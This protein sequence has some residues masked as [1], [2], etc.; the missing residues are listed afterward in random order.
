MWSYFEP[1]KVILVIAVI[2]SL[3]T[4]STNGALAVA[5]KYV[6]DDIFDAKNYT[7]LFILPVAVMIIYVAKSSF[8][9]LQNFLMS[10]IGNKVIEKLRNETFE[11]MIHLPV[12][13]YAEESTGA[14]MSRITN[15]INL[16]QSSIPTIINMLRAVVTMVGLIGVIIYMNW[17]LA[18]VAI[19][20][21]PIFI[22]PLS[23]I[24]RKLRRYS[25]R[26]QESMGILTSVLQESFSGIRVVKAFIAENKEQKRFEEANAVTIKY[27]NKSVLAGSLASPLTEAL[28]SVGIA[29]VLFIGGYQVIHGTVTTGQFFAFLAA[30][31]QIYEPVKLFASSNNALQAAIAAGERVFSMLDEKDEVMENTGTKECHAENKDIEFKNVS[32]IYKD[33]IYAL[34][35][36]SFN[37]KAGSTVAF[38]G[39]SGAGKTTMAHLIPRFYDVTDGHI[40][41]DNVDIREYDLYSLRH[42]ISI[43]SQ[44]AFLFNDTISNNI[45]Y[46]K[47]NATDE[48]VKDAARAAYADE[49][50]EKFPEKY[51]TMCGERGVKLSGGQKQRIT[52][53]R[54]LLKNPAILILDEAT[55]A[56]DTE[57]ERVVQKALDNLMK[58]RTSFVIAHRLSTILNADM[59]VV[60]NKGGVEAIGRHEEIIKTSPTYKKLYEMQ[61]KIEEQE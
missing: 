38:V 32:F 24:S 19:V 2:A 55:S 30:L 31:I 10:Y 29:A 53:A 6:L 57:S 49:F 61:F 17:Q 37:V 50:I 41:I 54:A 5:V 12:K 9:F 23:V 47:E 48:E 11:K 44:D 8:L 28:G 45:R 21:Y 43:V 3:I 22:Y 15:D 39:P 20:L 46:S 18:L 56:L 26:G 1:Y 4:A 36:V 33:D 51:D 16:V 34:K 13:Y 60:F 14:L 52:I 58:G 27:A 42:N 35:N 40:L 7:Y 25:T 59:I